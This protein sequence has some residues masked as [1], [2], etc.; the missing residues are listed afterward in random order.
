MKVIYLTNDTDFSQIKMDM[1]V[2][3]SQNKYGAMYTFKEKLSL[4]TG[5]PSSDYHV[6]TSSENG[7]MFLCVKSPQL[8]AALKAISDTLTMERGYTFKP[9]KDTCY[10]KINPDQAEQIPRNQKI[11]VSVN[12][13][14]VFNQTS[15]NTSFL[16]MEMTG[17][18]SYPLVH[19]EEM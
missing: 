1:V 8:N 7:K 14:G 11:N 12:V 19:F 17:F 6:F 13:Y 9:E 18:K 16:Q 10:I 5:E 4:V 2:S 15:T 3:K